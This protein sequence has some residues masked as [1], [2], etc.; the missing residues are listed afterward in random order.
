MMYDVGQ[1]IHHTSLLTYQLLVF[2]FDHVPFVITE[3][4]EIVRR[5]SNTPTQH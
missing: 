1:A 3:N 5:Q 2:P 4:G